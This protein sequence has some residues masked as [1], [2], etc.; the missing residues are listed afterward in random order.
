MFVILISVVVTTVYGLAM[1]LMI[2]GLRRADRRRVPSP[3]RQRSITL[4][5]AARNEEASLG[6]CLRA[7][8][9]QSHE[10][11][12]L[13][14]IDDRS[15]D[16]TFRI[17]QEAVEADPRVTLLRIPDAETNAGKKRAL[18]R[19]INSTDS[20]LLV[21]TD[22][23]CVPGKRWL[24]HMVNAFDDD[25]VLVAGYAPLEPR[26]G[27]LRSLAALESAANAVT[28]SA[29]IGLGTPVMCTAR[30]LAYT[31]AAYDAAGGL[32][33]ILDT[34]SGDDTLMLQQIAGLNAGSM[35]YVFHPDARVPS[36]PPSSLGA[37]LRQKRRHLSTLGHY[38]KRSLATALI[39]RSLD[40]LIVVGAP[41]ALLGVIG[42]AP[43]WAWAAKIL[44]D[45]GGL[46]VGL[47]RLGERSLL[48][49]YPLLAL[50]HPPFIVLTSILASTRRVPW[51]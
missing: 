19:G 39:L 45:A 46:W 3:R 28:A 15:T 24:E 16:G 48:R 51:K 17:A 40:L 44:M 35:R 25:T 18:L 36:P 4:L 9:T 37:L 33:S 10:A 41:L 34:A 21:F 42:P 12:D 50:L 47:G 1:G 20:E 29:M 38:D 23:D 22:A 8:L 30:S 7:V 32:E 2:V 43:L 26:R 31:R 6:E 5:I 13:V 49:F 27:L 14:I 11:F